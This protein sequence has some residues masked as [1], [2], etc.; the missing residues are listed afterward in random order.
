MAVHEVQPSRAAAPTTAVA[1]TEG[2][3]ITVSDAGV[4]QPWDGRD[5]P[6]VAGAL[7]AMAATRPDTPAMYVPVGPRALGRARYRTVTY[8]ALAADVRRI[9]AGLF[10]LGI[11]RGM[12]CALMVP[13]GE[14]FFALAFGLFHAGVVP[15]VVDPGIGLRNLRDCLAEAGP[16]AFIGV[17]AAHAARVLLGLGGPKVRRCVTVGPRLGW[18]GVTLGQVR[19]AGDRVLAAP[20]RAEAWSPPRVGSDDV[21]AIVFTSGSTGVPK[22]VVYT[23]GNFA[24]QI[25]MLRDALCIEPGEVDLPTF[26]LFALF[27]PALG[28]T[29]VIPKMDFTRPADV[30][31]REIVEPVRLFGVQTMFGSPALLDRVGRYAVPRGLTLPSLRRVVSAGAPVPADV[32]ARFTE[33]LGEGARVLTP[34]GATEC[35]PVTAVAHDVLL[36]ETAARTRAGEG[37]CIG[38]PVEG[39]RV[40]VIAISD[41]PIERWDDSLRVPDGTIGEFVVSGPNVTTRY[42]ARPRATAL[43]KIRAPGGEVMHRM[44][45]VGWRDARGR[46]WFC[47]RKSH[48]VVTTAGTLFTEPCEAPFA[49]HPAVKRAALV[50]TPSRDGVSARPARPVICVELEPGTTRGD[51]RRVLEELRAIAAAHPTTREIRDFL[52]HPRFPV[53]IRHNSKVFRERLADWATRRLGPRAAPGVD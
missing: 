27:G 15:V 46:L 52:I 16:E 5:D 47:G 23:H 48:R 19:A 53:D 32:I 18:S 41:D 35:L 3:A 21:A 24:A 38:R 17:T 45:D 12:H 50:G 10:A 26:P 9:A 30:D 13:P 37:V 51:R 8:A 40:E 6:N 28:M 31:P 49:A 20:T 1:T 33:M 42:H 11:G 25:R 2:P 29:T 43:A 44:G 7:F 22:G 14:D 39:V 34:Y 4:G 36:G